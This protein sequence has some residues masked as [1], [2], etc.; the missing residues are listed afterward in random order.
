MKSYLSAKINWLYSIM[1]SD[2]SNVEKMTG[3]CLLQ[4]QNGFL[5]LIIVSPYIYHYIV[6][7]FFFFLFKIL[8]IYFIAKDSFYMYE[9]QKTLIYLNYSVL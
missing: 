3:S 4:W 9:I 1:F 8:L 7:H 2:G 6:L 5:A